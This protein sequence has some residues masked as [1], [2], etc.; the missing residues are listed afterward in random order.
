METKALQG[1]CISLVGAEMLGMPYLH[2][3]EFQVL[4]DMTLYGKSKLNL[5]I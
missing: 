1:E 5:A 3:E 4:L 2:E